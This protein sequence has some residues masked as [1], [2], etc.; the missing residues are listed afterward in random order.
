M[1]YRQLNIDERE[2]ILEMRA[3]GKNLPDIAEN[4]GAGAGGRGGR[5]W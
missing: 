1:G 2:V 5:R 3:K 4:Y